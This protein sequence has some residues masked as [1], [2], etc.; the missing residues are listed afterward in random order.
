MLEID[1]VAY[2]VR[3]IEKTVDRRGLNADLSAIEE[4]PG[5]GTRELYLGDSGQAGRLLL[6]EPIGEGPYLR[7]LEKRGEGLHHVA[8]FVDDVAEYVASIAGSGWLLHPASVELLTS[9]RQIW[10]CRPG[11]ECLFEVSEGSRRYTTAADDSELEIPVQSGQEGLVSALG[12][13]GLVG[14]TRVSS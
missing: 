8:Y 11:V 5:E 10:L 2:V 7:A 3:S 1:H 9:A 14:V 6:M 13:R 4:F 12:V